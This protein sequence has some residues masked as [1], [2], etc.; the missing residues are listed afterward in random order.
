MVKTMGGK[1][2]N[3]KKNR[4]DTATKTDSEIT[5]NQKRYCMMSHN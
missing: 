5:P 2:A 4:P 1:E 3:R